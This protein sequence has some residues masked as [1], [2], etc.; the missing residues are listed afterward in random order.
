MTPNPELSLTAPITGEPTLVAH[1]L[2]RRRE[3]LIREISL[4][5]A[6]D[7]HAKGTGS[8]GLSVRHAPGRPIWWYRRTW[9]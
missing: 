6:A 8:G 9:R 4:L 7:P 2:E 3:H 1:R 5:S